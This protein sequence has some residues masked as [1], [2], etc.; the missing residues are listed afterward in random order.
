MFFII[1]TILFS[2]VL[3]HEKDYYEE[4]YDEETKLTKISHYFPVN[5]KHNRRQLLSHF[6]DNYTWYKTTPNL[7]ITIGDCHNLSN[8]NWSSILTDVIYH[9][10]NVP[11]NQNGTGE[12]YTPANVSFLQ[13]TC[14]T[15][16]IKSYNND[17]GDTNWLGRATIFINSNGYIVDAIS[18][19]NEYYSLTTNQWQHVLCQEIGHGFPLDHQSENG[20]DLNTCM[21]YDIYHTNKYPNKHDVYLLDSLYGNTTKNISVNTNNSSNCDYIDSIFM[22]ILIVGLSMSIILLS[23]FLYCFIKIYC[24]K[25]ETIQEPRSFTIDLEGF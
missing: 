16:M 20:C 11:E 18:K 23:Y 5:R 7:K 8:I 22:I 1:L 9:W 15:A 25:N 17:Y 4:S 2:S 12:I 19:V 21:D 24:I 3:C 13:T 6:W 10:N 14:E